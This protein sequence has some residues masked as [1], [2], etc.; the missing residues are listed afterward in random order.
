MATLLDPVGLLDALGAVWSP[1]LDAY[2]EGCTD[3]HRIRCVLCGTAPCTC[4]PFG[5]PAYFA[6]IDQRRSR[7]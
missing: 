4:P 1:D 7:R 3:A 2:A 6:L 5:T